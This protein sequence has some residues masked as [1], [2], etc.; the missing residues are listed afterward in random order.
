MEKFLSQYQ[1]NTKVTQYSMVGGVGLALKLSF[2]APSTL[3]AQ[4]D[5]QV[6]IVND[7]TMIN[8]RMLP[9]VGY[10]LILA[11]NVQLYFGR[12]TPVAVPSPKA[13]FHDV[14]YWVECP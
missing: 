7:I 1:A 8:L 13:P 14:H 2:Y 3:S 9:E 4:R 10:L 5:L 6:F 11:W 12:F